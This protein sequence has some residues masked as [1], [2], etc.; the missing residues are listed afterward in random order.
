MR[1]A[2]EVEVGLGS[3]VWS[4]D[5]AKAIEVAARLEAGTTWINSHGGLHPMIP[6]GGV[7]Q[8]GYGREF[9][10]EGL[11]AVANQHVISG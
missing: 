3:S 8:S 9:G 5:R 11:Q 10:V 6:F 7:K 1:L 4:S 2:N